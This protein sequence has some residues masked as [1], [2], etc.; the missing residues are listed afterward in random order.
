[1]LDGKTKIG[2][3]IAKLKYWK[4]QIARGNLNQFPHLSKCEPHD[5]ALRVMSDHLSKLSEDLTERFDDLISMTFSTWITQPYLF[6]FGSDERLTVDPDLIDAIMELQNDDSIKPIKTAK[7]LMMWLDPIVCG[8]Y[9][10]LAEVAQR[11]I[12][13]FPTSISLSVLLVR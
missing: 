4:L 6:D 2:G 5:Y 3:F 8:K 9:P 13:P 1:M 10:H 11:T 12:I 7:D